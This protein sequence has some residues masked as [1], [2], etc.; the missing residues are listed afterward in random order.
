MA[1]C[2]DGGLPEFSESEADARSAGCRERYRSLR[3]VYLVNF[4]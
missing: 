4:G 1:D 3:A 2:L